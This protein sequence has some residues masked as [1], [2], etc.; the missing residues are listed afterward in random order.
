MKPF[1]KVFATMFAHGSLDPEA[2][3]SRRIH[4]EWDRQRALA[5]SP[6]ERA[7]IDAIFSRSL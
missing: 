5:V 6:S 4:Q 7:E 3:E 1:S 2:A